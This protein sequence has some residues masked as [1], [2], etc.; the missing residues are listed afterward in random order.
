MNRASFRIRAVLLALVIL[1][2]V[3][4]YG[5]RLMA[6]QVVDGSSYAQL[7]KSRNSLTQTIQAA[8][9]EMVDRYG[10]PLVVNESCFD[11]VFDKTAMIK[12]EENQIILK[13]FQ[14]FEDSGE[15]WIDNLP[16]SYEEPFVFEEGADNAISRLKSFLEV[17]EYA[18][19]EDV[20][21]SL[22]ERYDL[23]EYEP[24][25]QRKLAGVRYEME[26]R[27]YSINVPYTFATDVSKD[28][29]TKV[30]ERS[31]E[32][33]GV[34]E[35]E[36]TTRNYVSGDLAPSIIGMIGPI[37]QEEYQEYKEKGYQLNDTIG[38]FGLEK[39]FESVLRG[40]NGQ[41]RI[42]LVDGI[43]EEI[44]DEVEPQPGNT[45]ALTI[46][47]N[48]Q[49]VTQQALADHVQNLNATAEPLAGKEAEGAAAVVI[50]V[51]TG[52]I[53]VAANYP[54]YNLQTYNEDYAQLSQDPLH[55]LM[56][57]ALNG[58]YTPGSI[59]KPGVSVAALAEGTLEDEYETVTCNGI[60]TYFDDYQPGCTG[61]HGAINVM[62]AIKQSCNIFFYDVGRRL[63]IEAI[64]RY[65]TMF[66]FGQ[67]VG[68]ELSTAK[69]QL[70]SPELS[71]SLGE[72]WEAGDVLQTSIGQ[73]KTM[74]SP[75]QLASYAATIAN[76]GV[77]MQPY[78]VK[79]VHSYSFDTVISQTQP[80]VVCDMQVE[81]HVFDVVREGME[82]MASY[83]FADYPVRVAT[84]TGTPQF[85]GEYTNSTF[86]S[87][88]PADDP[89]I[90]VA[91]VVEKGGGVPCAPI[92][93][94]IY[95]AYFGFGQGEDAQSEE[96]LLL[97]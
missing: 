44:V 30:S 49:A 91:V 11:I 7:A 46:D 37:Y 23:Q 60:Y 14:L 19:V 2:I 55:P 1:L 66:G 87:F 69:G 21:L 40:T 28:L 68:L 34:R 18:S 24:L 39:T 79:S 6:I 5:V 96:N 47:K 93:K 61:Y 52:E 62:D 64:D 10:R 50:D 78:L 12:G 82:R 13:M 3:C 97:Q 83:W 74:A 65:A 90:A 63:G 43:V 9:G 54:S 48:L 17:Q 80:R 86:I 89:Q 53:L 73:S 31:D 27:G 35:N 25:T 59:F 75:L 72:T 4:L 56:N 29:V 58:T 42:E 16:V 67:P 8:R 32:L 33:P 81:E 92:V 84:K 76:K 88:A 70:S 45:L 51:R 20:M 94:T 57:R 15:K 95:D 41:R 22:V 36:S 85:Y 26:Q 71:A 77:R 38:K